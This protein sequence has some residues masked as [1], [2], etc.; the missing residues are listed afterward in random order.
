M[1]SAEYFS[2]FPAHYGGDVIVFLS[3]VQMKFSFEPLFT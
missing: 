2:A 1:I 3:A